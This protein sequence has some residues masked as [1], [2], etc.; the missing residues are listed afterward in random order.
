VFA[1]FTYCGAFFIGRHRL[2]MEVAATPA[3]CRVQP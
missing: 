3:T 1:A 2:G